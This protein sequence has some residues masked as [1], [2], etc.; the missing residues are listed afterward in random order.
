MNH[1][2]ACKLR[3]NHEIHMCQIDRNKY[4]GLIEA[5]SNDPK[6]NCE[7]CGA[8]ANTS[9]YVCLPGEL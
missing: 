9:A 7:K 6:V 2:G 4:P 8:K 5:L 3:D 1:D